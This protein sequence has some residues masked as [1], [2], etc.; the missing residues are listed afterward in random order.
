MFLRLWVSLAVLFLA[1]CSLVGGSLA[2]SSTATPIADSTPPP[3]DAAAVPNAVPR[4]DPLL[5][6]G[7]RSPYTVN[8]ETYDILPSVA[9]YREEGIASWY[10]LKF[11]SKK[12][13]NGE[14]FNVYGPTAAHKTLPIPSYVRVT[15][16]SN[17]RQMTLRVNDRGPF[18]PD[19]LIDLSY[20]AAIKLGFADQGTTRVQVEAIDVE[21]VDDRRQSQGHYRFLQLGAFG[22]Q[23]AALELMAR[24]EKV[25]NAPLLISPVDASQGTL[26][27]LRA[28]P[29]E[30]EQDLRQ[31][32]A[33]LIKSGLTSGQPLP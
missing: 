22:D 19:R 9:G 2:G 11:H 5:A 24:A 8:G 6:A 33:L 29:F 18:H 12:T 7:N 14:V 27:R 4:P 21:G 32:Q 15:N 23:A 28:G 20:G 16:L 10:G 13:S 30:S 25:V 17:G 1:G 31:A 26:Y 3:I